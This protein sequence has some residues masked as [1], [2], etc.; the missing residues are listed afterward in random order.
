M[1]PSKD[2]SWSSVVDHMAID[3]AV[4]IWQGQ[5]P[6]RV[7]PAPP[8]HVGQLHAHRRRD[9]RVRPAL[10][11]GRGV[12]PRQRRPPRRR[13]RRGRTGRGASTT[14]AFVLVADHGMEENDPSCRATGTSRSARPACTYATR[15]TDSCTSAS[16]RHPGNG[17]N[18]MRRISA[19]FA[20]VAVSVV[21][22]AGCGGGGSSNPIL[23]PPTSGG[24]ATTSA[25]GG[26][27]GNSDLDALAREAEEGD[28]QGHLRHEQG[29]HGHHRN[30]RGPPTLRSS[31]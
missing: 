12:G 19:G 5:L 15:P 23:S 28:D 8:V 25:S 24:S 14:T 10:R 6:R 27:T 7:V 3:Q 17:G 11:D 13:A 2:Y 20:V 18:R 29:R 16:H 22:L 30:R 21:V 31:P 9:A 26:S 4:G 1:R